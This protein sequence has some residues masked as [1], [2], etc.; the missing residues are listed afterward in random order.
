MKGIFNPAK[1]VRE[2]EKSREQRSSQGTPNLR[3]K[4]MRPAKKSFSKVLTAVSMAAAATVAA[5]SAQA[6]LVTPFYGSDVAAAIGTDPNGVFIATDAAGDNATLELV[7]SS[8]TATTI[9]L[10]ANDYLFLAVDAVVT[11]NPNVAADAGKKIDGATQPANLG[12]SSIGVQV[13]SSDSN[14]SKLQPVLVNAIASYSNGTGYSTTANIN[15]ADAVLGQGGY[16]AGN[17][18]TNA[19]V[20][21]WA[22]S[23]STGDAEAHDGTVGAN[24]FAGG[25]NTSINSTKSATVGFAAQFSGT[26]ATYAAATEV[27]DSLSYQAT[28]AGTVTLQPQ[29]VASATG[30]WTNSAPG[31]NSPASPAVYTA[32]TTNASQLGTL[33]VLVI[34]V[35]AGGPTAHQ[36]VSLTAG[37]AAATN[38]GA[39]VGSTV[40]MVG[41]SG[42]YI[43]TSTTFTATA[44]GSVF[45][46]PWAPA[47][48]KEIFA[49]DVLD[50]GNQ[51]NAAEIA[52][53]IAAINGDGTAP[54]SGVV[55]SASSPSPDP[56]GS[57]YNLFLTFSGGELPGTATDTLG[58][59]LSSTND[60][61]LAGY[62]FSSVAVVPEPMSLGLLA[63]GG[64]GL[65]T[66]RNRRKA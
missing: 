11:G 15:N 44:T 1:A 57:Q 62:S 8:G 42:S 20:P 19:N 3:G 33:P 25:G 16:T 56:F 53:L 64:V 40:T 4:T 48:D 30:Y 29:I 61:K 10:P 23:F 45:V 2:A 38:Y 39:Q 65:M 9:N 46:D 52:T 12:L 14:G 60:A 47:T 37:N 27:F 58:L 51:A 54:A 18:T 34:N 55:A 32:N 59:D 35:V 7:N 24:T 31:S 28:G 49:V 41:G 26:S 13:I 66:R 63:L 43:V 6:V 22:S 17:N 5:R 36:V 50:G 21:D